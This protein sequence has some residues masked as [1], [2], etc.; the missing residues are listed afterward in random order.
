[1]PGVYHCTHLSD[2]EA[3]LEEGSNVAVSVDGD[4][5]SPLRDLTTLTRW[6]MSYW[7]KLAIHIAYIEECMSKQ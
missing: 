3:A 6:T 5:S 2:V 7:S 1:M 4:C